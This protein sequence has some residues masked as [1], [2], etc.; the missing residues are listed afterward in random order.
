M[1][2]SYNDGYVR[3]IHCPNYIRYSMHVFKL[4]SKFFHGWCGGPSYEFLQDDWLNRIH[5][6]G[7]GLT[8]WEA[9]SIQVGNVCI[10]LH[11]VNLEIVTAIFTWIGIVDRMFVHWRCECWIQVLKCGDVH[12]HAWF[13]FSGIEWTE[14][15][16][17]EKF[18]LSHP[19]VMSPY[20]F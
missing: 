6:L 5:E 17:I 12:M 16:S 9:N 7:D 13:E 18:R 3:T 10:E 2:T 4:T 14:K 8:G 20:T 15:V 1:K 19:Y 11:V